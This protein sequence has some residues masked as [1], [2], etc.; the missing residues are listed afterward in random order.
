[1]NRL[2]LR[3]ALSNSLAKVAKSV[4]IAGVTGTLIP[5]CCDEPGFSLAR[6]ETMAG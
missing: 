1:M 4:D 2:F 5:A 3:L 6:I